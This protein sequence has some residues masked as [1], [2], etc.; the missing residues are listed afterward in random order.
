MR[1]YLLF[2]TALFVFASCDP[3]FHDDFIISNKCNEKIKVSITYYTGI[4]TTFEIQPES[5]CLFYS[6]EGVR[7]VSRIEKID[8]LFEDIVIQKGDAV[9]AIDYTK[10]DAWEKENVESSRRNRYY[11]D[12]KYYLY[13][14]PDDFK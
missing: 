4:D 14:T 12:V 11:T 9:S 8:N 6:D 7:G 1:K 5:E 2:I 10:H 3:L 13:I